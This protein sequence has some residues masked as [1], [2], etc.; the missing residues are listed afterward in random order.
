MPPPPLLLRLPG[1]GLRTHSFHAVNPLLPVLQ[2]PCPAA[3][4]SPAAWCDRLCHPPAVEQI[5]FHGRGRLLH[6]AGVTQT[7]CPLR[8]AFAP[9]SSAPRALAC[10]LFFFFFFSPRSSSETSRPAYLE[11]GTNC[12]PAL[13]RP[14]HPIYS[15]IYGQMAGGSEW[16]GCVSQKNP[17]G[18]ERGKGVGTKGGGR[19]SKKK[20]FPKKY[21]MS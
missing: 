1:E 8:A 19:K 5:D 7:P 11:M 2:A 14:S 17:G 4:R 21:W 18:S 15:H 3:P 9:V 10:C 6:G 20:P 13:P 16:E 12:S